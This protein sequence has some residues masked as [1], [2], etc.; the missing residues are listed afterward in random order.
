MDIEETIKNYGS[1]IKSEIYS[2]DKDSNVID[3]IFQLVL[4]RLWK[5]APE[6]INF[7]Y[8]S[9]LVKFAIIDN[10]RRNKKVIKILPIENFEFIS[11]ENADDLVVTKENTIVTNLQ[12]HRLLQK[13]NNLKESQRDVV[14]LRISGYSFNEIANIMNITQNNAIGQMYYAKQNLRK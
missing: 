14:L 4:I 10:Y 9:K 5:S 7:K 1:F 11:D 12:L 8:L 13:I 2:Y 6:T 3:E